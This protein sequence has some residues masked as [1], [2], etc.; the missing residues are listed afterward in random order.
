MRKNLYRQLI[1]NAF[2][3]HVIC[4]LRDYRRL[5][6]SCL[7]LHALCVWQISDGGELYLLDVRYIFKVS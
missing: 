6:N 5:I 7:F 3:I 1:R 4:D 2:C